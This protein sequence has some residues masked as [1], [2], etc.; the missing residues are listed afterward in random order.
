M[1][2]LVLVLKVAS[3]KT[4]ENGSWHQFHTDWCRKRSEISLKIECYKN[5]KKCK[6]WMT[7]VEFFEETTVLVCSEKLQSR[8]DIAKSAITLQYTSFVLKEK[9][10]F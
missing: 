3:W 1:M 5:M 10:I 7:F 2:F 4:T 6:G 8:L 9:G